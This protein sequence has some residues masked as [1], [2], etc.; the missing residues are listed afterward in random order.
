MY[1]FL[2]GWNVVGNNI[3]YFSTCE[4]AEAHIEAWWHSC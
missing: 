1:R 2:V 4:N 3:L